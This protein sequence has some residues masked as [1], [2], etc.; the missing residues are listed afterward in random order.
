[1]SILGKR[2]LLSNHSVIDRTTV[3]R[4]GTAMREGTP[5]WHRSGDSDSTRGTAA[6][7]DA[8][9]WLASQLRWERT[10]DRLRCDDGV[11]AKAA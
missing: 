4:R 6:S 2:L 9:H 10:L 8:L 1:M 5:S 11:E 7:F 3:Q